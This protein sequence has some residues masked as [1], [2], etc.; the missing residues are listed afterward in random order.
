[1]VITEGTGGLPFMVHTY[2]SLTTPTGPATLLPGAIRQPPVEDTCYTLTA[3][4]TGGDYPESDLEDMFNK[5]R[6]AWT[7][8]LYVYV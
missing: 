7:N 3:T 2:S 6:P 5:L 8:F 1:M 4:V